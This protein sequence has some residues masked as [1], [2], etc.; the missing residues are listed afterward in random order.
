MKKVTMRVLSLV[1]HGLPYLV[2]A[3]LLFVWS[4]GGRNTETL[5]QYLSGPPVWAGFLLLVLYL[6]K[7]QAIFLPFSVLYALAGL[8]FSPLPALLLN[9][10]GMALVVTLPFLRTRE[11]G[12]YV[13]FFLLAQ[14][15]PRMQELYPKLVE[16]R[17]ICQENDLFLSYF[18]RVIGVLPHRTVSRILRLL[19]VAY[20]PYL[21]GSLLG[22][23]PRLIAVTMLGASI[24]DPSSPAF[25]WACLGTLFMATCSALSYW[26]YQRHKARRAA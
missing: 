8:L 2:A 19:G 11:T 1:L 15:Y 3:W 14:S 18:S 13:A 6:I 20:P 4:R 21:L 7:S 17:H 23:L 26:L 25:L 16:L 22:Y 9:L 5:L 10:L 12:P 24:L